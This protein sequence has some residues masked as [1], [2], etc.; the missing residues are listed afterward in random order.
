M[1]IWSLLS[2]QLGKIYALSV[3][4]LDEHVNNIYIWAALREFRLRR[5]RLSK[6][7]IS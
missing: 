3:E 6:T 5:F 7:Q 4:L 1:K 2:Y